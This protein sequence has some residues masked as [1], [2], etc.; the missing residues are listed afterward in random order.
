MSAHKGM[1]QQLKG[2]T[3][4][5]IFKQSDEYRKES[6]WDFRGNGDDGV[7]IVFSNGVRIHSQQDAE[8]NGPGHMI[9]EETSGVQYHILPD[10]SDTKE[11]A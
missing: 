6:G 1:E 2:A 9:F 5:G 4:V 7:T 11:A 8:G 10:H 3:V